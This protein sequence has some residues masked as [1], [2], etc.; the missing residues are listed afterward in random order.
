MASL[1]PN[2]LRVIAQR[3]G[4]VTS[5]QL[6]SFGLS[7]TQIGYL[8]DTG[9]LVRAR[10]SVFRHA[11]APC[12]HDQR[13][14][15]ACAVSESVAISHQSAGRK[16]GLRRLGRDQRIHATIPGRAH[17]RIPGVVI[18][19]SHLILPTDVVE[20][21]DGIRLT[22]VERTIFDLAD[23]VSDPALESII[24]QA[25]HDELCS[26]S[27]LRVLG[28]RLCRQGRNGSERFRRVLDLRPEWWTA[29]DTD[30]ELRLEQAIIAA[31]LPRPIRQFEITL[32]DGSDIHPDFYWPDPPTAL[33]VDHSSWHGGREQQTYDKWR[34][35]QLTRIGVRPMRVSEDDIRFRVETVV[36]DLAAVLRT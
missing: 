35:R 28:S 30:L 24:E 2:A 16:R 8:V 25:V 26:I 7:D 21:D 15:L 9:Q 3:H 10:H 33:E 27:S 29:V 6:T 32:P 13:L 36:S 4:V 22:S 18:H 20:Q 14:A 5:E 17:L 1:S 12:T 34:D 31:G 19:R 11:A 23:V